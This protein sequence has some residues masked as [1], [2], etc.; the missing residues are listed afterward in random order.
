M[1][2]IAGKGTTKY[3]TPWGDMGLVSHE[4]LITFL[5]TN[6][7]LTLFY[8]CLCLKIPYLAYVADS[9]TL[10]SANSLKNHA[11]TKLI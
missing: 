8:E 6:K 5:S 3:F 11:L 10:N 4:P 7:Y 2:L 9:L 1:L